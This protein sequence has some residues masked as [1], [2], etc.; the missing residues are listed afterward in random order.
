MLTMGN[1][2][3]VQH[4]RYF[5]LGRDAKLI[6]GRNEEDNHWLSTHTQAGDLFIEP[7]GKGPTAVG[8][9]A[10]SQSYIEKALQLVGRYC[11]KDAANP[12]SSYK[13]SLKGIVKPFIITEK[14]RVIFNEHQTN[15]EDARSMHGQSASALGT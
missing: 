1:A 2:R 7:T 3:L 9:G 15:A 14:A 11:K 10:F 5:S 12:I 4:G 13:M 8:R 6:V